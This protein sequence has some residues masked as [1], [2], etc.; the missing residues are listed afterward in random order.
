M[1][2]TVVQIRDVGVRVDERRVAVRMG[3][4]S[5]DP[6]PMIVVVVLVV[7]VGVIVLHLLVDVLVVVGLVQQESQPRRHEPHRQKIGGA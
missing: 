5:R 6:R 4:R 2:V 3:V 7:H 1:P